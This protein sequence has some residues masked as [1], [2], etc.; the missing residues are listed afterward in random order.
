MELSKAFR[1]IN[2]KIVGEITLLPHKSTAE[3]PSEQRL[4][5]MMYLEGLS[6]HSIETEKKPICPR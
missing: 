6:F 2:A 5:L 1:G 3:L 4:G